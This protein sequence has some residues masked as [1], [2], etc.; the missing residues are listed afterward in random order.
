MAAEGGALTEAAGWMPELF[1]N[2]ATASA[3]TQQ[4]SAR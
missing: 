3:T 1:A 4:T 2:V